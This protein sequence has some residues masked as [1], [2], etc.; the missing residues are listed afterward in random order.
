MLHDLRAGDVGRGRVADERVAHSGAQAVRGRH[1]LPRDAV[2]QHSPDPRRQVVER[3][4][5]L[6]LWVLPNRTLLLLSRVVL[7]VDRLLPAHRRREVPSWN[8]RAVCVCARARTTAKLCVPVDCLALAARYSE[9]IV[10]AYHRDRIWPPTPFRRRLARRTGRPRPQAATRTTKT[11]L[12][13]L[14]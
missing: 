12:P 5:R 7:C 2:H 11:G 10:A 6:T 3:Q 14:P 4:V 8:R 1:V 13:T 9:K